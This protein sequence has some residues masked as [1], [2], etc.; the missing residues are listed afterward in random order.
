MSTLR[1]HLQ[2]QV[3]VLFGGVLAA[4]LVVMLLL[5]AGMQR[6]SQQWYLQ[7]VADA[8]ASSGAR[9]IAR[10]LNFIALTNRALIANQIALAQLVGVASWMAM[11]EDGS[12]RLA[13][14]S[15]VIPYLN[16]FTHHL[17]QFIRAAQPV[18]E[19][20]IQLAI[21][22]QG[23]VVQAISIAQRAAHVA[24]TSLVV[25]TIDE[26][27]HKHDT[28]LLWEARHTNGVVPA[29]WLWWRKLRHPS[30]AT[31]EQ[32]DLA[33]MALASR[34]PFSAKRSYVW[35]DLRLLKMK[36]GGG[37]ELH[38]EPGGRWSW[39]ALDTTSL[40]QKLLFWSSEVQWAR[41]ARY[42]STTHR[43]QNNPAHYGDS[44]SYNRAGTRSAKRL[45]KS[46]RQPM[47]PFTFTS[48]S[49]TAD[50]PQMLVR[51]LK[52]AATGGE[53][54]QA[55]AKAAVTFSRPLQVFARADDQH[56]GPNLFNA[57]WHAQLTP[58]TAQDKLVLAVWG[59]G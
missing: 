50:V 7:N 30:T 38:V 28:K 34:D 23:A 10:E 24:F 17:Q 56:E 32:V 5:V 36:K 18:I 27:T 47:R 22:G 13:L 6:T 3:S 54:L 26:I 53:Q 11:L 51:I 31:P 40:H 2:G 9:V 4:L 35:F 37:T 42:Q 45:A 55:F 57:L 59:R 19:R 12:K 48:F 8:A 1:R 33:K 44:T 49:G 58:L 16:T 25:Q 39:Q 15:R 41:G 46:L 43:Y 20:M 52:P 14:I 21:V 29:P